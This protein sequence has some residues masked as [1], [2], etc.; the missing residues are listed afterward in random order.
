MLTKFQEDLTQHNAWFLEHGEISREQFDRL[1]CDVERGVR[2]GM[3]RALSSPR[4]LLDSETIQTNS[5]PF[6]PFECV[7]PA[8]R[9]RVALLTGDYPPA[10]T[11]GVGRWTEALALSL[12]ELGHEVHVFTIAPEVSTVDFEEGVFVH[13]I[14]PS[15]RPDIASPLDIDL[16]RGLLDR[17]AALDVEVRRCHGVAPFDVIS[18]P[19]WDLPGL[20]LLRDPPCPTLLSLHS[21]YLSIRP[22][23]PEWSGETEYGALH[24]APMI[25]AERWAWLNA[26]VVI[27]NS[28]VIVKHYENLYGSR[29][30]GCVVK[31][32]HG[33]PEP[34]IVEEVDVIGASWLPF[35]RSQAGVLIAYIGRL[36]TRKGTDILLDAIPEVLERLPH[37]SF[38][39]VGE[40]VVEDPAQKSTGADLWRFITAAKFCRKYYLQDK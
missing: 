30:V 34:K 25:C 18:T 40:D 1:Q 39:I 32:P 19:I 31:V 33:I 4:K 28:D 36:E 20:F 24:V 11:G 2:D 8:R 27:S 38:I 12:N 22:Y 7:R 9:F 29:E 16:S 3:K 15:W 21:G 37:A 14:Q 10:P 13:R 17:M 26:P 5:G 35:V 6:L 23:K